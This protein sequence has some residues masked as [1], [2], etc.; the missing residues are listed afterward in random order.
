MERQEGKTPARKFKGKRRD[1]KRKW[2]ER[3]HAVRNT[4][5]TKRKRSMWVERVWGARWRIGGTLIG[6]RQLRGKFPD[7]K[8]SIKVVFI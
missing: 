6:S 4:E 1:R 2:Q 5:R 7:E 3:L 8:G